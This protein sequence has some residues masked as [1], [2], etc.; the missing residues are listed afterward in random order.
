MF[1]EDAETPVTVVPE[2]DATPL[3]LETKLP[4]LKP[5]GA[6]AVVL[7][8]TEI[9]ELPK[10]TFPPGQEG[11]TVTD[12]FATGLLTVPPGPVQLIW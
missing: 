5:A 11:G 9:V 8:P 1:A 6:L 2:T 12:T 4:P 10:L 7:L 3:L